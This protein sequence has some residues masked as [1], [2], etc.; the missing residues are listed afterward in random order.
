MRE[1]ERQNRGES[2]M[3]NEDDREIRKEMNSQYAREERESDRMT[4][5]KSEIHK[6]IFKRE[7]K[8]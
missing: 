6:E 3:K 7:K 1:R 2:T 8:V 4:K 5:D